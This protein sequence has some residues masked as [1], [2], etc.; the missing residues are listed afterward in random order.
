MEETDSS[1]GLCRLCASLF[2]SK[3]GFFIFGDDQITNKIELYLQIQMVR[4][5]Y[6]PKNI[7]SNCLSKIE[8]FH[9]FAENARKIQHSFHAYNE[10]TVYEVQEDE[11]ISNT[12][13]VCLRKL[14]SV[15]L[16]EHFL[17]KYISSFYLLPIYCL[18][19]TYTYNYSKQYNLSHLF[20]TLE[21]IDSSYQLFAKEEQNFNLSGKN[22]EPIFNKVSCHNDDSFLN[23]FPS[24]TITTQNFSPKVP[25]NENNN[26][27]M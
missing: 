12:M 20:Q 21:K 13:E 7:C 23:F 16:S 27:V 6:L 9:E 2:F 25:T 8:A 17:D 4:D 14:K 15:T 18:I 3:S 26:Q 1:D 5:D 22:F 11:N 10:S 24:N 19:H